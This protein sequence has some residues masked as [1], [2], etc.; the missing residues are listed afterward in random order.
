MTLALFASLLFAATSAPAQDA[1]AG[2]RPKPAQTV[3]LNVTVTDGKGHAVADVKR[4]DL[5]LHVDGAE[6]PITYFSNA[7]RPVSYGLVVDNSGSLRSQIN[8]VIAAAKLIL[9]SNGPE[10]ETFALRF[11]D[12]KNITV[13]REFTA[14]KPSLERALDGMYVQGGLTALV[15]ALYLSTEYLSKKAKP[16]EAGARL[17]ALVLISDGEDRLSRYKDEDLF[18]L[19]EQSDVQIFCIGL[20]GALDKESG[21]TT[22]SKRD[23]AKAFLERLASQTGGRVFF[24]VKTDELKEAIDEVVKSLHSQLILGFTPPQSMKGSAQHKI[25]VKVVG[26]PGRGK[27]KAVTRPEITLAGQGGTEGQ[28]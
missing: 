5:R 16:A 28:K 14:D 7:G 4:E 26:G 21:F 25:E 15:D 17:R 20:V 19:L 9:N 6:Q 18:K 24:A 13:V 23:R 3:L 1:G 22:R 27:L 2:E 12:S 10:D 11:V 8:Y